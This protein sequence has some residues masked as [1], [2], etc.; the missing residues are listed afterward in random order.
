MFKKYLF[1]LMSLLLMMTMA[2]SVVLGVEDF[3]WVTADRVGN[4]NAEIVLE[5]FL[6]RENTLQTPYESRKNYFSKA[7]EAWARKHPNVRININAAIP[8]QISQNMSK[9][10]TEAEVGAAPDILNL[11]SFWVGNFVSA[12]ALQTIDQFMTQEEIDSFYDFTKDVT[13]ANGKQY[14]I[15][16]ETDAR[17]LYYNTE[18]IKNP[19]KTW[20][21]LIEKALEAKEEY[22]VNGYLTDAG[23]W[24]GA[25]NE[26]TWPYFWAQGGQIFDEEG[27]PVLAQG[28]NKQ[29]LIN[30][31]SFLKR[32]V[33]TGAAPQ[34]IAGI[35]GF[36]PILAE[37][38]ANNVA[39]FINGSWARSQLKDILG[40]DA[41]KWEFVPYPQMEASQAGNSNGGW[42]F[43]IT[44]EDEYKRSLAFSFVWEVMASKS[45]MAERCIAANYM[46][47]RKDVYNEFNFFKTDLNQ[48]KYAETLKN[49]KARPA[50]ILYPAI[51]DLVQT[52]VGNVL[53]GQATPEEAVEQINK[54]AIKAWEE[55]K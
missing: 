41:A 46:P 7:A 36:D 23:H 39:M 8:G 16:T 42:T 49:G 32:L 51:S 4:P 26:N 55:S 28:E 44:T 43:A 14:A 6:N 12:G 35:T 53:T 37:V 45:A 20:D 9:L 33:D 27:K 19:P 31:F 52:A 50:S 25:A 5:A 15:W 54:E 11:D 13:M 10:I 48:Q 47:T 40:E 3:E 18:M 34:K 17:F 1:L 38:K 2:S 30:I 29:Y 24:E 21:E 22:G